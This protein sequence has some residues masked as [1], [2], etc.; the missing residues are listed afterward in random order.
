MKLCVCQFQCHSL[1][2][3]QRTISH[4]RT[5]QF[6]GNSRHHIDCVC[7]ADADAEAAEAAAVRGVT[8]RAD[9]EQPRECVVLQ[10]NLNEIHSAF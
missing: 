4:L 6:P 7:A 2:P 9:H 5:L 1:R 3:V 10:Q 8:V